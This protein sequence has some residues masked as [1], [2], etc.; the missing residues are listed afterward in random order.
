MTAPARA[1]RVLRT[2]WICGIAASLVA[3]AHATTA[4][5]EPAPTD[6]R[7]LAA[8]EIEPSQI[9]LKSPFESVQ[10]LVTGRRVDGT[11]VDLTREAH[12]SQ[13]DAVEVTPLGRLRPRRNGSGVLALEV[14]G[15]TLSV[16]VTISGQTEQGDPEFRRDV[17]PV[18]GRLGCNAGTC[19]GSAKGKNG[20][21]LS[22]RGYDPEFDHLSLTDDLAGRRF[23]PVEPERSLFLL[24]PTAA[25]AHEGGQRLLAD[26]PEYRVLRDWVASGARFDRILAEKAKVERIEL[27]P[28]DAD[29][30]GPGAT[31]QMVVRATYQDGTQRDVTAL[32][33][34]E[35]DD[36]E[37]AKVDGN[38]VVTG[39]RRG[40]VA[41]LARY[42]GCY[43]AARVP[44]NAGADAKSFT[45]V[46]VPEYGFIDELV[47]RKLARVKMLPSPLAT[48]A[49]FMRRVYLDLTG[50]PPTIK[51]ART[52]LD[53]SRDSKMKREELIDRLIGS[54]EFVDHW[55]RKW[56][57]LLQVN[58]KFLGADGA[59]GFQ[60]WIRKA[61]A[62]NEPW[63]RFM[64]DVL[65]ASGSTAANPP[66]SYYKVLRE[67]DVV[68]ENTTQL[69]LGIRF[70]CNKC[71]DHPFERWTRAQHWKLAAYFARVMRKNADG[72]PLMPEKGGNQPDDARVA[73]EEMIGDM[74]G[75][76]LKDP[77]SGVVVSPGLPYAFETAGAA[78]DEGG[79]RD[80]VVAWITARENPYFAMS[81]VNR[82]W[83][84]FTGVGFIEPVDDIRATNPPTNPE[85]LDRLT[86]EFVAHGFDTRWL[87][88]EICRSRVY[89]QS[90]ETNDTNAGDTRNYSHATARRLPAEVLYD[91]V[92]VATGATP[93]LPGTR[94]GT[95]A[96]ETVDATL[97]SGDGFL[98]LFGRPPRESVC[99]CE[100]K[101][102]MSLGQALNLVNGDT[103]ASALRAEGNT[104]S[105]LVANVRDPKAIV[106]ELFLSFLGREPTPEET[107][108]FAATLDPM[109]VANAA[110]LAPTDAKELG[111][112]RSA[113][114]SGL[115]P[116][117]WSSS[118]FVSGRSDAGAAFEAKEDGSV[119]VTG[120][121]ADK[122]TYTLVFSTDRVGITGIRLDAVPDDSLPGHGPGR[123]PNGNF[124]LGEMR[125][126]A[127]P[128]GAPAAAKTLT[129]KEATADFAQAEFPPMNAF[130]GKLETGFAI[131]PQTGR[132]HS[133]VAETS[134]DVPG[135]GGG[136][137][138]VV[139]IDQ[140]FGGAHTLGKF[141][142]SVTTS[143]R[144]VRYDDL[145]LPVAAALRKAKD[146]RSAEDEDVLHG[147][148]VARD[149]EI[150][151][152]IRLAATQDL[153]WALVNSKAF[154]FNR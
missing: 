110:A 66:A 82:M 124:V 40:E 16:P 21:K 43:A 62:S 13:S 153:A 36:P 37:V 32:A 148:Y 51:Q 136:V 72:S 44:I 100:R 106:E 74:D 5:I 117:E 42:E 144:P 26:S 118:K 88:R 56:A 71:H 99:E 95:R 115:H 65:G 89:Q 132:A 83:S 7:A 39:V 93:R 84:Y 68:M 79:R 15:Q 35:S 78:K 87:V 9:D 59:K 149:P 53:D 69:A 14:G 138:L 151:E 140:R 150:S 49:E 3:A 111:T 104:I 11:R 27:L 139:T 38:G 125:V 126:V 57:D 114:E 61:V 145:P 73:Y 28:K 102:G 8:I 108:R 31:Q 6:P 18:L 112:R 127:I 91:A 25:I 19:H 75:G 133:L 134:E 96:G 131:V 107:T 109:R 116:A 55:T 60:N 46:D 23:D 147:Y 70:S 123:A 122:D 142:L 52:F 129:L 80:Q 113:F 54:P 30:E 48:D 63:D 1:M 128:F 103:V 2:A 4:R 58:A 24:K 76:E 29:L 64:R 105:S 10:L 137:T 97:D 120:P 98:G 154:L 130:D 47:D 143:K 92:F 67:P 141:R 152:R 90:V 86:K 121:I 41:V 33:F 50:L 34:V 119:L 77:D 135:D 85:L 45:W 94:P 20:F 101:A 81:F 12:F 146:S 17:E 22:L